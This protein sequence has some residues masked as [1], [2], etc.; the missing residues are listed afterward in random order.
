MTIFSAVIRL[1]PAALIATAWGATPVASPKTALPSPRQAAAKSIPR[2]GRSDREIEQDIRARL[3]RSKISSD[4]F[5][6]QVQGGV[7]TFEG[8]TDI[9]QHKGVATRMA[10]SAGAGAVRNRIE[11]S[12]MAKQKLAGNLALGRRR[13]QVA[14]SQARSE[15]SRPRSQLQIRRS[16]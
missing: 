6:V 16:R 10:K 8:K 14:R 4:H 7:A 9:V 5:T 12:A 13:V 2:P 11:I 3:S 15:A 1:L